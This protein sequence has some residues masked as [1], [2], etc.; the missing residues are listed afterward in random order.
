MTLVAYTFLLSNLGHCQR[1]RGRGENKLSVRHEWAPKEN[2]IGVWESRLDAG[3]Q[4]SEP[5]SAAMD[6]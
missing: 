2:C 5:S 3:D 6:K 1:G 4:S